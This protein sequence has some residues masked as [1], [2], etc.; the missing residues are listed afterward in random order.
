MTEADLQGALSNDSLTEEDINQM[1]M[2]QEKEETTAK[3][4]QEDYQIAYALDLIKGMSI[5][6]FQ[7]DN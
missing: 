2:D 1:E 5:Y 3:K 7:E 6:G 4:R